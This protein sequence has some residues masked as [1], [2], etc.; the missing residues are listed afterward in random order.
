MAVLLPENGAYRILISF[1]MRM[2]E[3]GVSGTPSGRRGFRA[4]AD[5]GGAPDFVCATS[6]CRT[7]GDLSM[8]RI[9]HCLTSVCLRL[10]GNFCGPATNLASVFVFHIDCVRTLLVS[11][12]LT[13]SPHYVEAAKIMPASL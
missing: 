2:L 5:G 9:S 1:S 11:T 8:A 4:F 6:G 10:P 13:F 3:Q 7:S 12:T